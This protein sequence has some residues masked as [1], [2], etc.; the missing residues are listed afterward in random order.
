MTFVLGTDERRAGGPTAHLGRYRA[1]DGSSGAPLHLDVDG[2]HA[3][4][5]VGKRGY[6]KSHTVGVLA[7]EL[8]RVDGV[9][10]V[11]VD[12][13]GVFPSLCEPAE[14]EP[15]PASV[16]A[17]PAVDPASLDPRSW[18]SLLALPAESAAGGLVWQAARERGSL[19]GMREHAAAAD[20]SR[21]ARRAAQNHLSLAASWGVFD[22]GGIDAATLAGNEATVLD[23][24]GLERAP[25]NAVLRGVCEAVYRA[26]V[27]GRTGRLPWLLVDEAH[28]FFDGV[29]AGGLETLLTRGRGPGVS[30]VLATQR[31]AVVPDVAVSQSDVLVAHRLTAEEGLAA[32]AGMQPTYVHSPLEQQLPEEPGEA[33]IVDDATETVHGVRVRERVTPHGGDSPRVSEL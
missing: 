30:T 6:G 28:V 7:E 5:V 20:A 15:V 26:R 4:L 1:V 29:G 22:A 3:L 27:E 31:P 32:L 21:S 19:A 9:A 16:L 12:P 23:L 2:P 8:A 11:V 13:V 24:S 18:C 33:V 14:G 10:P 17:D 25:T